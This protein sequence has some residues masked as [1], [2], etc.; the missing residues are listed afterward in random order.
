MNLSIR[1]CARLTLVLALTGVSIEL[2]SAPNRVALKKVPV[3]VEYEIPADM[4]TGDTIVTRFV[5]SPSR[6]VDELQ[7]SI[8]PHL[9]IELLSQQRTVAGTPV[10][11]GETL[12]L[13]AEVK[14]T[15]PKRGAL[16]VICR[17]RNANRTS[18]DSVAVVYG[19]RT[20]AK[21]DAAV[22]ADQLR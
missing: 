12:T 5:F 19:D 10:K 4:K 6:D 15:D 8:A 21:K 2:Q 22:V 18:Q 7:I 9:G 11:K 3:T 13:D 20:E 16:L 14:L 1:S 17:V